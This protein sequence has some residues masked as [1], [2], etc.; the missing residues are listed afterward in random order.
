MGFILR[1]GLRLMWFRVVQFDRLSS[2]GVAE[3]A[4]SNG[5]CAVVDVTLGEALDRVV[6]SGMSEPGRV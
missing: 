2:V 5:V 1:L 3:I 6:L 4:G